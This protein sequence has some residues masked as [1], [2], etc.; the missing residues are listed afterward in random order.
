MACMLKPLL[1]VFLIMISA[2]LFLGLTLK[3]TTLEEMTLGSHLIVSGKVKSSYSVWE[4]KNI[5]TYYTIETDEVIKGQNI[6]SSVVVKQLGGRVGDIAQEVSGTPKLRDNTEA[7]LFLVDW[8]DAYWIH[9]IALGYYQIVERDGARYAVNNF[10]NVH[11]VD[12]EDGRKVSHKD[13]LKTEY[14]LA[15]LKTD[16]RNII[17]KVQE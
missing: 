16:L 5:Y 11:F 17:K 3:Y 12:S 4:D 8:K 7:L 9:S 6:G 2:V 15:S 10:N 14:D 13:H 1:R